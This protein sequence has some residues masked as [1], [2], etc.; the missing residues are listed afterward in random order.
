MAKSLSEELLALLDPDTQAKVRAALQ[1]K[2][3]LVVRDAKSRELLDIFYGEDEPVAVAATAAH[4]PAVPS[5]ATTTAASVTQ[6]VAAT[7]TA[8]TTA[9][10]SDGMAAVLAELQ[11]LKSKMDKDYVP[12]SKLGE[13]RTE[14]LSHAI[15]TADDYSTIRE[16]HRAE[17]NEP[18]DRNAYEAFVTTQSTAGVKYPSLMAAHDAFVGEK[19]KTAQA[20]AEKARIDAGIAEGLKLA[21]SSS[22]VPGQTQQIAASPA[23]Q[24]IAKAK[25]TAGGGGGA[26]SA[27]V[28]AARQLEDLDRN[29]ATVQ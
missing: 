27:A 5:A 26:E 22:S 12:V 23:Q 18:L 3:E 8:T 1:S 9:S 19:R 24:V 2:P 20:A 17:F 7:T 21:R 10:P 14:I 11:S 4:T 15:K 13:Y 28:R 29:R 16:N 6:P 25:T